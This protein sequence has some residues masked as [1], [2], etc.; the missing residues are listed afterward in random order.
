MHAHLGHPGIDGSGARD[1]L[2]QCVGAGPVPR[3]RVRTV[4]IRSFLAPAGGGRGVE[5]SVD[6]GGSDRIELGV[7]VVHPG[8]PVDPA[9][10]PSLPALIGEA[11]LSLVARHGAGQVTALALEL[12]H[13]VILGVPVQGGRVAV[14]LGAGDVVQRVRGRRHRVEMSTGHGAGRQRRLEARHRVACPLPGGD[15]PGIPVGSAAVVAEHVLGALRPP[16]LGQQA[17]TAGDQHVEALAE[18]ANAPRRHD[19]VVERSPVQPVH[20]DTRE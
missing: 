9:P 20:V 8:D 14:E 13:G 4:L 7:Q 5:R 12:L 11:G 2:D 3:D 17:G 10:D 16:I 15:S 1:Q 18:P 19:E 6:G